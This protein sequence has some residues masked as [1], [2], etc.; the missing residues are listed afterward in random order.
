MTVIKYVFLLAL[1]L[2][3]FDMFGKRGFTITERCALIIFNENTNKRF[4]RQIIR[5]KNN[6]KMVN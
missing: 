4:W 6:K 5:Y 1:L 2:S 3:P